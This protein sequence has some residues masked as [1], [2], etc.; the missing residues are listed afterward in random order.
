M[1]CLKN[2]QINHDFIMYNTGDILVLGINGYRLLKSLLNLIQILILSQD[3]IKRRKVPQRRRKLFHLWKN[4][5]DKM[6]RVAKLRILYP[7]FLIP[8]FSSVKK[9]LSI[10]VLIMFKDYRFV[11]GRNSI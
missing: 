1:G 11:E 8:T 9:H 4:W 2:F 3:K 6:T 5:K 7:G 10:G